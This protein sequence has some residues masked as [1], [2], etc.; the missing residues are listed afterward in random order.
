G[1]HLLAVD[2]ETGELIVLRRRAAR[3]ETPVRVRVS[4]A[5]VGVRVA[6]DGSLCTV[7][8]LWSR[9][10][11]VVGLPRLTRDRGPHVLKTITPP[12]PL[13]SDCL[14]VALPRFIVAAPFGGRLGVVDL[15]RVKVEPDRLLPAHNIRGLA[16]STDGTRLLVSH[17]ALNSQGSTS[18]DDIHWGNLI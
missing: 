9:R 5:P 3:L 4:P 18:R 14:P 11:T 2:E 10:L 6:A 15:P 7:V 8:S 12:F 16:L 13:C 17:Q 1:T